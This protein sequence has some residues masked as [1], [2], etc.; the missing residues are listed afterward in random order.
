MNKEEAAIFENRYWHAVRFANNFHIIYAMMC[1]GLLLAG[2]LQFQK[3]W[4]MVL[5][6]VVCYPAMHQILFKRWTPEYLLTKIRKTDQQTTGKVENIGSLRKLHQINYSYLVHGKRFIGYDL[7]SGTQ[8]ETFR[9]GEDV[10]VNYSAD[11]PR[12]SMIKVEKN[13]NLT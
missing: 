1:G 3:H 7:I 8:I 13:T 4:L 9:E 6:A 12:L 11:K 10:V 2:I 5:L